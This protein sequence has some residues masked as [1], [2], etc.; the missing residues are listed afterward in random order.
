M[1][2]GRIGYHR[3]RM[4]MEVR[5]Q[6]L[7]RDNQV[8]EAFLNFSYLVSICNWLLAYIIYHEL[9]IVLYFDQYCV[10]RHKTNT[11]V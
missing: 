9:G 10:H 1:F 8:I 3:D 5:S 6:F 4:S 11:T 2:K 7:Y